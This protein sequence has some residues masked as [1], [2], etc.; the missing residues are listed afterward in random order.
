V[1]PQGESV[2]A[3][4][5]TDRSP[6]TPPVETRAAEVTGQPDRLDCAGPAPAR[7]SHLRGLCTDDEDG[8]PVSEIAELS[9][10]HRSGAAFDRRECCHHTRRDS[11]VTLLRRYGSP[12]ADH[13]GTRVSLVCGR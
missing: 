7:S 5:W 8:P 2:Q 6:T 13:I 10:V 12:E 11:D 9:V 4:G 1:T 3:D